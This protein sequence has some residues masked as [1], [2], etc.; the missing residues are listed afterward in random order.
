MY[1]LLLFIERKEKSILSV[2]LICRLPS[3][4]KRL[5]TSLGQRE[6]GVGRTGQGD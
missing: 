5:C 6:T 4:I 2:L 1:I 3:L